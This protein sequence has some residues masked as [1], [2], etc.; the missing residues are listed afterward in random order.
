[1]L[2]K[3]HTKLSVKAMKAHKIAFWI[4]KSYSRSFPAISD[5]FTIALQQIFMK[6]KL[7]Q[8]SEETGEI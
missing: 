5:R 7:Y 1:M 8:I 2:S 3:K 6:S 4:N